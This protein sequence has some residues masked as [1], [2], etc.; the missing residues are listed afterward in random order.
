M[1]ILNVKLNSEEIYNLINIINNIIT[2][3]KNKF[4]VNLFD[5]NIFNLIPIIPDGNFLYHNI[6]YFK[7]NIQNYDAIIKN[8]IYN[9]LNF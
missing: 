3:N 5:K 6:S 8:E 2:I 7:Y 1:Q 4:N 9:Y